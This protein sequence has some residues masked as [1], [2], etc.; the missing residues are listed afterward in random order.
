VDTHTDRTERISGAPTLKLK[1]G[2][3]A[4]T[5]AA[6]TLMGGQQPHTET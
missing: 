5:E 4:H 2:W 3:E 6:L 1:C